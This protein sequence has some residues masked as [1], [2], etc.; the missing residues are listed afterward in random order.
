MAYIDKIYGTRK[1][2][3]QLHAF[4]V[5]THPEWI[6]KYMYPEPDDESEESPISNFSKEADMW[7]LKNC[8]LKF[9][10]NRIKEQYEM[11]QR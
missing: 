5:Q 10:T 9:V 11:D 8:P 7:L 1:Q 3:N 4:L 6:K 2:W